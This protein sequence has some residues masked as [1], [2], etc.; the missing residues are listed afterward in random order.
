MVNLILMRNIMVGNW[1][2]VLLARLL[3]SRKK[4]FPLLLE[5][6]IHFLEERVSAIERLKAKNSISKL[7]WLERGRRFVGIHM[8]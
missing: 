6:E 3:I 4:P 1:I 8:A 2:K 7:K 5:H